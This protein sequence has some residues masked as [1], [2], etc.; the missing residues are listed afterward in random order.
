MPAV[1]AR[2]GMRA[3]SNA[4]TFQMATCGCPIP[5]KYAPLRFLF[6]ITARAWHGWGVLGRRR[7]LEV[8]KIQRSADYLTLVGSKDWFH[9]PIADCRERLHD[10][11]AD[12][13]GA[14]ELRSSG[15]SLR[16]RQKLR[17]NL[18]CPLLLTIWE[19]PAGAPSAWY[20]YMDQ[21]KSGHRLQA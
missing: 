9:L 6:R 20:L 11:A 4:D 18:I 10:D 17:V 8:P 16:A 15:I 5:G 13:G 19:I 3:R 1:T 12:Y 2:C 14:W 7:N 21:R